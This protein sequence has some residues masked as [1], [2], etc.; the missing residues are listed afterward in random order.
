MNP[1]T[2]T[3]I[4]S[5]L[6]N[7]SQRERA[8][9]SLP[10]GFAE[11]DWENRD[12]MGWRDPKLPKFGYAVVELDGESVGVL[13]READGR[14]RA[15]P[16]CSWCEDVTLPNDVVFFSA[17]RSGAAGRRGDTIGTLVC[18]G[19]QCSANARKRPPVA[20]VGFDVE[21]ARQERIS[22]LHQHVQ[23]F[24]RDVRDGS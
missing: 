4:R 15:R 17:K 24:I 11:L 16:Q 23:G 9:L 5:S 18:A 22:A 12:F 10:P 7:A 8:S 1:L 2:E 13:L 6:V 19:F 21:A 20:Y 14:I 3:S